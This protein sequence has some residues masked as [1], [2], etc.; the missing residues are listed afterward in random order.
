MLV[1]ESRMDD[2]KLLDASSSRAL[3]EYKQLITEMRGQ[4]FDVIRF[5]TYR[6]ACKLK[7]IQ[8]KTNLHLVD[9]WNIIESFRENQL[10][11][12]DLSAEINVSRLESAISSI[13][14]Q[15]N[16]RL[17]APRQINME[18][19]IALLLNWLLSVYDDGQECGKIRVFSV[20]VAL[21]LMCSGKLMDKLRYIFSQIADQNTGYLM[22]SKF[23]L[24]LKECLALPTAMYEGPSFGYSSN[25][26]RGVFTSNHQDA[27][28]PQISVNDF[29]DTLLADP[30]PQCLLWLPILHRMALVRAKSI[31]YNPSFRLWF[32]F[33]RKN[34]GSF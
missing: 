12:V 11:G 24:F 19:S 34:I 25:M 14:R 32:T 21:A 8:R 2:N 20:K 29:L 22:L 30:G 27:I 1:N 10:N 13:Y 33:A 3:V 28:H 6:T 15:L 18:A 9:L 31:V 7:F 23:D 17:P 16:K 5:A 4:N 26:A